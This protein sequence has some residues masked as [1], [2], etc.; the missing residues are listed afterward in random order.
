[1][2]TL[3]ISAFPGTGKTVM[4]S[5]LKKSNQALDLHISDFPK[6]KFPS[7]Y[8]EHIQNSKRKKVRIILVSSHQAV[9]DA[10]VKNKIPFILVYPDKSLKE[11][12]LSRYCQRGSGDFFVS[13]LDNNWYSWI[14]ECERQE[15]CTHMRLPSKTYLSDVIIPII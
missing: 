7:N 4:R 5:M 15:Y 1:M 14:E 11:E 2:K 10:L 8:I 12:Y 3:V 13:L 9:R 6:D